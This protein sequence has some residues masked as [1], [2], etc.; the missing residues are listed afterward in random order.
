MVSF[1]YYLGSEQWGSC[2]LRPGSQLLVAL[3][4]L[5]IYEQASI[6]KKNVEA[7]KKCRTLSQWVCREAA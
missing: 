3:P 4:T 7:G 5:G 2:S 1:P 6:I